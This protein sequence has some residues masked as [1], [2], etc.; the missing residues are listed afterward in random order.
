[1]TGN[2]PTSTPARNRFV[3]FASTWQAACVRPGAIARPVDAADARRFR[4]IVISMAW[5]GIMFCLVPTWRTADARPWVDNVESYGERADIEDK[6]EALIVLSAAAGISSAMTAI[7]LGLLITPERPRGS[8]HHACA[9]LAILVF[10]GLAG[11]NFAA[12]LCLAGFIGA[13][14]LWSQFG[15][16]RAFAGRGVASAVLRATA[17]T[18]LS[19]GLGTI[20]ALGAVM[21]GDFVLLVLGGV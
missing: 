21:I 13:I 11:S 10:S 15:F 5:L 7:G 19:F 4:R 17:G 9:P 20:A 14:T 2:E 12:W 1:M 8:A 6:I 18:M 3:A 16:Q